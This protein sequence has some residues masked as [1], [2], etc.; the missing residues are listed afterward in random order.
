VGGRGKQMK[1]CGG[2]EKGVLVGPF[3]I[4][5]NTMQPIN[6]NITVLVKLNASSKISFTLSK[7]VWMRVQKSLK[8][9]LPSKKLM[10]DLSTAFGLP[11]NNI[12]C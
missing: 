6:E 10:A 8:T 12:V 7:C 5:C 3:T 1:S 2:L 11:F 4:T 9:K